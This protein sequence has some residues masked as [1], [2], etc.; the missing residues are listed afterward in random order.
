MGAHVPSA[1]RTAIGVGAANRKE[2]SRDGFLGRWAK[3][4]FGEDIFLGPV[5]FFSICPPS[6][7]LNT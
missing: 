3:I 4:F 7:V 6:V 5:M 1:S 2:Y